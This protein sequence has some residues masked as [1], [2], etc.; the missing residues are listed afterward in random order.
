[1]EKSKPPLIP[2]WVYIVVIL[3]VGLTVVGALASKF[4]PSLLASGHAIPAPMRIYTDYMFSRSFALAAIILFLFLIR[5][6]RMLAGFMMMLALIQFIDVIDDASRGDF[7]LASGILV[8][9]IL[10]LIA[11][12]R[13]FGQPLWRIT[14]WRD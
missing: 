7:M 8:L 4:N 6:R 11:A 12:W 3:S 2:V 1:M 10:F 14:N 13:L 5:A 9:A